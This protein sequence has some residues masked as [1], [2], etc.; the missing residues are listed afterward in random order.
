MTRS[1]DKRKDLRVLF[2]RGVNVQIAAIDGT[3]RRPC[4]MLDA[5][6]SGAK[7]TFD[8]PINDLNLSEFF[9]VLSTMGSA[10]RRCELAWVN[11]N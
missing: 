2:S 4:L 10:F 3:W 11:G 8:L 5:A 6:E 7:L 1:P 9:L